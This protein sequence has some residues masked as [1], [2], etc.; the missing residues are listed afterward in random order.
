MRIA[1][2]TGYYSNATEQASAAT[3]I[4]A[5]TGTPSSGEHYA[6]P[7]PTF[8][9]RPHFQLFSGGALSSFLENPRI[10]P[11]ENRQTGV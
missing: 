6:P 8:H 10:H 2:V 7:S 9:I 1:L 4:L 3:V 11:P 5:S